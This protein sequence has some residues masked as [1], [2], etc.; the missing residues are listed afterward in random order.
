MS[1]SV[2]EV[3]N[4]VKYYNSGANTVK[5]VDNISFSVEKG[6]FVSIMGTSGSG[7]STLLSI[8]STI[9][10][11]SSGD[12]L[13]DGKNI[14]EMKEDE[15]SDFR[16]D[17]LGFI[18]QSY[19]LLDTLTIGENIALPLNLKN[20]SAEETAEKVKAVTRKLGIEDLTDK[21]PNELSGGQCQRA[22]CARA[23]IAEPSLIMADE[24]TGALDSGNSQKFMNTL[25]SMNKND[26]VTILMVT[27][28]PVVG[29]YADRV[30]FLRD[31]KIWNEI[32][33]GDRQRK[34]FYDEI[35]AVT[36]SA[37]G[38]NNVN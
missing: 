13:I 9:E 28:D 2:L 21:F 24:P 17:K 37:G 33:K 4:A 3:K 18:F 7:K 36:S 8:I 5:A 38:D 29:S 15:R 1:D 31:G 25:Q 14:A 10:S 20:I 19:N 26:K 30:M 6:E 27:H 23:L 32:F 35:I 12:I 16:R 22:A 11:V 34:D